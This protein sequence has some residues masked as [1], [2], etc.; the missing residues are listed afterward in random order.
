MKNSTFPRLIPWMFLSAITFLILMSIARFV[1]FVH[2]KPMNDALSNNMDVFLLG[3]RFDLRIVCGLI[4]FP[5]LAGNLR[6]QYNE[7]KRLKIQSI[8]TLILTIAVMF[9][10]LLFMHKGHATASVLIPTGILFLLILFWLFATKNCNPFEHR[11]SAKIFKIYFLIAAILL[12]FFYVIDFQHF[13]YLHQRL[14]ASVI[15]YADDAKISAS[16]VWETYPIWIMLGIII[17]CSAFIY[18][19]ILY[20]YT[21]MEKRIFRGRMI[22]KLVT[23]IIF[24]LLLGLGLFGKWNQYP[25]RWSDAFTFKDDFKANL[26]LNPLQSFFSTMQFR[27]STFDLSKVKDDYPLM[28]KYLHVTHPDAETLNYNRIHLASSNKQT[29]NVV[30]VIC[31]S[32]SSYKSGWRKPLKYYTLF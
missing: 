24:T 13:D 27:N 19:L 22:F 29:P 26:A 7:K 5:F 30:V 6:L 1:F 15:N 16:M 20:F 8:L 17:V 9:V 10:L 23:G 25:L 14:N 11:V 18:F 28:A 3:L 2:F 21:L 31:E 4:L 32:F 12:A